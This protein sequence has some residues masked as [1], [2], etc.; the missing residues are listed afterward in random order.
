VD[1]VDPKNFV[2][3]AGSLLHAAEQ[4]TKKNDKVRMTKEARMLK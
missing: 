4:K 2:G 3:S 1:D